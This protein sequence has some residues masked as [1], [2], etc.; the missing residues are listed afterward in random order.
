MS[1]NSNLTP[2]RKFKLMTLSEIWC[3][4]ISRVLRKSSPVKSRPFGMRALSYASSC[5]MCSFATDTVGEFGWIFFS[6]SNLLVQI[7]AK[8]VEEQES[9]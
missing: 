1:L 2:L 5:S 9:K 7:V 6:F 4:A 8:A 3:M